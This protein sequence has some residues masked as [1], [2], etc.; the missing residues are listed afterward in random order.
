MGGGNAQKSAAARLKNLKDESKTPEQRKAAADKAKRDSE[1]FKCSVCLSTFMC[2]VKPSLLMTHVTARHPAMVATPG[3]CFEAL[4][5]YDP[6]DPDGKKKAS[7][8]STGPVKPKKKKV[9]VGLD[10]LFAAGLSG[11]KKKKPVRK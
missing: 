4:T 6:S 3:Q 1:A 8:S 11:G 5:N 10:D 7:T 9:E 2:N